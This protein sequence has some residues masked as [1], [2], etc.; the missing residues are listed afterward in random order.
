M[1][2]SNHVWSSEVQLPQFGEGVSFHCW[3]VIAAS[4]ALV[5]APPNSDKLLLAC[6]NYCA[7]AERREE[8]SQ[9]GPLNSADCRQPLAR[10][11]RARAG[12]T[13]RCGREAL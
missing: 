2:R 3:S 11:K 12:E 1:V 5:P 10:R 8:S 7:I 13:P 6:A 9:R 4:Y